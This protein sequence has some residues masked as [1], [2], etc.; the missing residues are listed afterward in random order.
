MTTDML[1]FRVQFDFYF[2]G[3]AS[4]EYKKESMKVSE[5]IQIEDH[6]VSEM[7]Q[8][9]VSSRFGY[10]VGRYAPRIETAAYHF[11]QLIYKDFMSLLPPK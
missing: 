5:D 1:S 4:E 10:D 9:G 11:H 2:K 7:V 6:W 3:D 8:Q